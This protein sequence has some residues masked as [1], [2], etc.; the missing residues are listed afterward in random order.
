MLI[1]EIKFL[2]LLFTV[3]IVNIWIEEYKRFRRP[4]LAIRSIILVFASFC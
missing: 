2:Q 1:I 3:G 4:M